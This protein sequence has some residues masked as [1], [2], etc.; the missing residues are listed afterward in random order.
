M[1]ILVAK[2]GLKKIWFHLTV[3]PSNAA[4]SYA[5]VFD[6]VFIELIYLKKNEVLFVQIISASQVFNIS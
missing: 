2:G 6:G 3:T 4:C 1:C 5:V